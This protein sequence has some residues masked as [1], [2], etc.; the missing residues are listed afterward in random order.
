VTYQE[1]LL[2]ILMIKTISIA[3]KDAEKSSAFKEKLKCF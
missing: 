1:K 2:G 3:R